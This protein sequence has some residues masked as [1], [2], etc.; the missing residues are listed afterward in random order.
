M[1]AR[2][3]RMAGLLVLALAFLLTCALATGLVFG[4][5]R[6]LPVQSGSMA[7]T[8]PKG[9]AVIVT[10]QSFADIR[11]GQI[12]VYDPPTAGQSLLVHRVVEVIR[13]GDTVSVRTRGDHNNADDPWTAQLADPPVWK[14]TKVVPYAGTLVDL[15]RNRALRLALFPLALL[16]LAIAVLA[17]LAQMPSVIAQVTAAAGEDEARR[18]SGRGAPAEPDDAPLIVPPQPSRP[19][20]LPVPSRAG[21]VPPMTPLTV[22]TLEANRPSSLRAALAAAGLE[23]EGLLV[24]EPVPV[25]ATAVAVAERDPGA[26]REPVARPPAGWYPDPTRRFALRWY[27][28]ARWTEHVATGSEQ[29]TDPLG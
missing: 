21:A 19:R 20:T 6:V 17:T 3:V 11:V 13:S 14:V 1:F 29:G 12:I 23:V 24:D 5:W 15:L 18:P 2:T 9:A 22:A 26:E 25:R 7:P 8:I 10:P 27:D 28:G 4:W 16:G